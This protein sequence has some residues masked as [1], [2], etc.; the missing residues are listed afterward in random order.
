MLWI[1][2]SRSRPDNIAALIESWK[3]TRCMADLLVVI[4]NDDPELDNYRRVLLGVDGYPWLSFVESDRL[5]LVGSL[6]KF[7]VGAAPLYDSIGF[8]GDDHRPRTPIWDGLMAAQLRSMKTGVVYG[9]D[10]LQG[11]NLPTEVV[12]TT[13]II[14][15]LGY[16]VPPTIQH[17]YADNFWLT[18]GREIGRIEYMDHV[19]I[20]HL[21]P[22]AGKAPGDAQYD[23]LNSRVQHEKDGHA[24][25]TYLRKGL[26]ADLDKIRAVMR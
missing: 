22:H 7:A 6:N 14:S 17:L 25:E 20:E 18:I 1:V 12:M 10:L 5:R 19:V 13:D 2:P 9:N 16:M 21:H 8:M 3:Q 11:K 4:D 23:E 24:F 26:A 15:A